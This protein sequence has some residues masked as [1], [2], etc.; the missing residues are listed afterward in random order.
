M[1]KDIIN[2]WR[3]KFPSISNLSFG[4]CSLPCECLC[5]CDTSTLFLLI[6]FR[7]HVT[8]QFSDFSNRNFFAHLSLT[9]F[10]RLSPVGFL[11]RFFALWV[12]SSPSSTQL[13]STFSFLPFL[14][15]LNLLESSENSTFSRFL[16][17]ALNYYFL[18]CSNVYPLY[19]ILLQ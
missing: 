2:I 8:S 13:V 11:Y 19:R 7:S 3:F 1:I 16:L 18:I 9:F 10:F 14:L 4:I 5:N 17:L 6:L 12:E 15:V